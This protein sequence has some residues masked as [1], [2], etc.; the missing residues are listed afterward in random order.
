MFS[1]SVVMHL[2]V[3]PC[4]NGL[5]R[6]KELANISGGKE[7]YVIPFSQCSLLREII[8]QFPIRCGIYICVTVYIL[9]LEFD[10]YL[11]VN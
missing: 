6:H 9:S 1:S 5:G 11:E 8:V 3:Y 7:Q 10:S 2:Q 4:P